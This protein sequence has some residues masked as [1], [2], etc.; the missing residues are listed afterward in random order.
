MVGF[1]ELEGD[2][3]IDTLCVHRGSRGVGRRGC[4]IG[5]KPKRGVSGSHGCT[6][7][8]HH[9]RTVLPKEGFHGREAAAR[10]GSWPHPPN[11]RHRE[12]GLLILQYWIFPN[13]TELW[14]GFTRLRDAQ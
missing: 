13:G 14:N 3:R 1:A 4:S 7:G 12:G 11:L 6:R 2:D 9:R 8:E 5:S 10:G